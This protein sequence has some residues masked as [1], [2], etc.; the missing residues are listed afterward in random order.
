MSARTGA[1]RLL[2]VT[3]ILGATGCSSAAQK[4]RAL[5][6]AE[7][8]YTAIRA[9]RAEQACSLLSPRAREGQESAGET[10]ASSIVD[11]RLPGGR[12]LETQVWGDE[13][14]VRLS[15]DTVFLHRYANGWLVRAAGCAAREARPYR[16]EIEG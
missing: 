5:A 10:C 1:V 4:P 7:G 3:L 6:A 9:G 11:L 12:S 2:T 14:Q 8:F 15:A 16:C 13:A